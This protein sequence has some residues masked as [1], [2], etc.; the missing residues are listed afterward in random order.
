MHSI[1]STQ[2]LSG[3]IDHR[4]MHLS[5]AM[6]YLFEFAPK[7]IRPRLRIPAGRYRTISAIVLTGN[8]AESEPIIPSSAI[9]MRVRFRVASSTP[10]F[11]CKPDYKLSNVTFFG[12]W[13][14]SQVRSRGAI[15]SLAQILQQT[16]PPSRSWEMLAKPDKER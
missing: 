7:D 10:L 14:A 16:H 3:A 4:I 11:R 9:L 5:Q 1:E 15:T 12:D 2:K 8:T 13:R 6:H